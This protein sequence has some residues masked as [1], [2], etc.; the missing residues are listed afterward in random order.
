MV[1]YSTLRGTVT[2]PVVISNQADGPPSDAIYTTGGVFDWIDF[3]GESYYG[4]PK[5]GALVTGASLT[6]TF[7]ST[8][9]NLQ[10]GAKCSV[11]WSLHLY[12]KGS[13][14]QWDL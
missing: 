14:W 11:D 12:V 8:L 9:V 13:F 6:F 2:V 10:T 5:V 1:T 3:P 7:S 4:P